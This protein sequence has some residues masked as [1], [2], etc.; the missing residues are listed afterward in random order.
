[1][2]RE[3]VKGKQWVDREWFMDALAAVNLV[4]GP[5][6]TE[7]AIHIGLEVGGWRG[8]LAAGFGFICPAVFF[9]VLLAALYMNTG[10]VPVF[11][12][13]LLGVKPVIL[14]LILSAA[15]RLGKNAIRSRPLFILFILALIAVIPSLAP[16]MQLG[17]PALLIPDW[18]LL[19]FCGFGHLILLRRMTPALIGLS[20]AA[21]T[22]LVSVIVFPSLPM[23]LLTI[24]GRF[25]V[26]G[27]TLFGSGLM[28]SSYMQRMFVEELGWLTPQQLLDTLVIGQSTPGPVLSTSAAAGYMILHNAAPGNIG[29]GVLAGVLAAVGVFFPAFVIVAFLGKLAPM[30]RKSPAAQDFLKGVNAAVIALLISAFI[31][32]AWGTL[33]RANRTVD[34]ITVGLTV[35]AFIASERYQWTALRL[36]WVGALIGFA[37]VLLGWV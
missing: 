22:P 12:G 20:G 26:I 30:I 9:S 5:N 35:V 2:E 29:V 7:M 33:I 21:A 17:F 6:S 32:I 18:S 37:R 19:L 3:L 15:Y 24:F 25:L 4:P 1:M 8:M 14:V 31:N 13:L 34:W 28:L 27:G 10:D 11:E 23:T 36:V 16:V